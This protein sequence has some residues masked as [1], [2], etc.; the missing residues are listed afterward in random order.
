MVYG[1]TERQVLLPPYIGLAPV[2]V[3][4]GWYD[5]IAAAIWKETLWNLGKIQR[6]AHLSQIG[7][8]LHPVLGKVGAGNGVEDGLELFP[9]QRTGH[10]DHEFP[11]IGGGGQ[12][13][14]IGEDIERLVV[15][16]IRLHRRVVLFKGAGIV[17]RLDK[18]INPDRVAPVRS[19]ERHVCGY[20]VVQGG[21]VQFPRVKALQIR[22]GE[23][24]FHPQLPE[25]GP[26]LP[27]RLLICAGAGGSAGICGN[28]AEGLIRPLGEMSGN[29]CAGGP[30]RH[31][32][33]EE[34]C[35]DGGQ[36]SQ[37][38]PVPGPDR[39]GGRLLRR[40][41][42]AAAVPV[43]QGAAVGTGA[44]LGLKPLPGGVRFKWPVS[45]GQQTGDIQNSVRIRRLPV[46]SLEIQPKNLFQ[47][48]RAHPVIVGIV[49][50]FVLFRYGHRTPSFHMVYV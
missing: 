38:S 29:V 14:L 25:L 36:H 1:Q 40:R 42:A 3:K 23:A 8:D 12:G 32:A 47:L 5:K 4:V 7:L 33:Q 41:G 19:G 34:S 13:V 49:P 50:L 21:N 30:G 15:V 24:P 9:G 44:V 48:R 11:V 18:M 22:Y 37:L 27:E 16:L 28:K 46:R 43:V 10:R 17:G 6:L 45:L 39:D 31:P 35:Q 20:T 2:G 26:E